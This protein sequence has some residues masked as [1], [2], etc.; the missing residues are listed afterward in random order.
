MA[1]KRPRR[2]FTAEFKGRAVKR[3]LDGGKG[4]S[5]VATERARHQPGAAERLA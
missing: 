2:R 4:L 3:L 5:E 1:E